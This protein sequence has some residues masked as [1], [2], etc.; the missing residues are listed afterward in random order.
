MLVDVAEAP[1]RR[2]VS[3]HEAFEPGRLSGAG[4]AYRVG[5]LKPVRISDGDG[6][7]VRDPVAE[8]AHTF[9]SGT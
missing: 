6:F 3:G 5:V 9:M 8:Y 4:A 7:A 1:P 2:E